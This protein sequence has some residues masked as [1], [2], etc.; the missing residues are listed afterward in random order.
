LASE[1]TT[2]TQA[3]GLRR[4]IAVSTG[5]LQDARA[6]RSPL[7]VEALAIA[8]ICWLY[9][10]LTNLAPTRRA[11]ALSHASAVLKIERTLG[12]DPELSLNRWLA[13]Q[14]ALALA[15]SDYY[16]NAHFVVTLG[17]LGLLWWRRADAYPSLRNALVVTNVIAFAVFWL[18]PMAPPRMLP[19]NGFVDVV[20]STHA[21]GSWHSGSLAADADQYAAMPSLHIAWAVWCVVAIWQLTRRRWLRALGLV[22]VGITAFVVLST[23][24]HFVLDVLGGALAAALA[25]AIVELVRRLARRPLTRLAG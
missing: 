9:D 6:G 8:W 22:H 18:W 14:H 2:E 10:I 25:F 16:D 5:W 21:F 24:N 15:L 23:G 1:L 4:R 3:I 7:W 20:A 11:V 13:G 17:L 19:G 12:I